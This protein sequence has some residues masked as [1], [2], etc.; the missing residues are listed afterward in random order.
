MVVLASG[1]FVVGALCLLDLLLTLGVVRRLREHTTIITSSAWRGTEPPIGLAAGEVP[2]PFA[3][4]TTDGAEIKG[5]A[6]LRIVAFF[7][8]TCSVCPKSVPA[9]VRYMRA[10]SVGPREALAI[11]TGEDAESVPYRADLAA[12][13][14]LSAEA[15]KGPVGEAF[16]VTGYP[17]FFVLGEDGVVAASSYDPARLPV[18][19]KV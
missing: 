4:P 8:T 9:F 11:V 16:G 19:V 6:G 18:P 14:Q 10:H 7:S 13:A 17:A 1:L 15:V 3:V 12:V 5:P 2:M